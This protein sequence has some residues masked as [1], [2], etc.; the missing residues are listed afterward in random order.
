MPDAAPRFLNTILL[1]GSTIDKL[2]AVQAAGFDAIELWRQDL[3][4]VDGGPADL[5]A[6]L[7]DTS[8]GLVD[9]QVLMDFD[10]APAEQ[11]ADKRAEAIT[12]L[13]TAAQLGADT[14]LVPASTAVVCDPDRIVD[15]LRWLADEAVSRKLRIAYEPMAWSTVHVDLRTA[16]ALLRELDR[17][18]VGLVVDAFHLFSI[19]GTVSD[20]A[21]IPADRVYLVQLSDLDQ[22]LSG[23]NRRTLIVTARHERLLPGE[24]QFPLGE[25][26]EWARRIGYAG[27]VGVEVFNDSWNARPPMEAARAAMQALKAVWPD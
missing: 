24:G 1:G 2:V 12:L 7:R 18:N 14:L 21:G 23:A 15:D 6:R 25:L 4:A 16:W 8:L 3:E 26:R 20:L 11:Q 9:Y 5:A 27:P 17:P 10:G 22:D 13:D 19:G